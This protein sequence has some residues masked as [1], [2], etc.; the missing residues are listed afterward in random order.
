[1]VDRQSP[2]PRATCNTLCSY[3]DAEN[4]RNIS[5]D[6][7][8]ENRRLLIL[9]WN[10]IQGKTKA[11]VITPCLYITYGSR[12]VVR[13]KSR[14]KIKMPAIAAILDVESKKGKKR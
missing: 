5:H 8:F 13:T 1:M 7:H 3:G 12:G 6:G 11:K 14:Q 10:L 4:N 9:K 2:P